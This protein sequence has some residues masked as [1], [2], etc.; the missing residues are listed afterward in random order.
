M[1]STHELPED[2]RWT[3][4]PRKEPKTLPASITSYDLLKALAL[5][6]M[7]ID[8][9]GYYFFPVDAAHPEHAWFRVLGRLS[10]PIWFFLIGY[11]KTAE[12][13]GRLYFW[14]GLAVASKMAAGEFILPLNILFTIMAARYVRDA[15]AQK[16][17]E[18]PEHMRGMVLLILLGTLPTALVLEYGSL[19]LF[20]VIHGYMRRNPQA[21]KVRPL[22]VRL[23]LFLTFFAYFF[24][25]G[26][27][28]GTISVDQSVVLAAGLGL[29]FLILN[30]FAPAEY[31]RLTAALGPFS[32][33]VRLTGRR[34]LELYVL[35]LILFRAAAMYFSPETYVF[36]NWS[37]MDPGLMSMIV[38]QG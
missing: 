10:V 24:M 17:L 14:A 27:T 26:A 30:R 6:F 21:V 15:C 37:V 35:H 8:H 2:D 11:A 22:Y 5:I 29:V 9:T 16:A 32:G 4:T 20:F 25:Q 12:V 13:P 23:F 7:L 33:L 3:E 18:S 38:R 28:M 19:V 1:T 36:W 31:P 34:T